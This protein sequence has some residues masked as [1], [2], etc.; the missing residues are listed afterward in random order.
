MHAVPSLFDPRHSTLTHAEPVLQNVSIKLTNWMSQ[1]KQSLKSMQAL[2][3]ALP[4]ELLFISSI[5]NSFFNIIF[6]FLKY[7]L[8]QKSLLN[9]ISINKRFSFQS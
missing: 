9:L 7:I 8:A 5:N 3:K 6:L 1:A 4:L 2:Y